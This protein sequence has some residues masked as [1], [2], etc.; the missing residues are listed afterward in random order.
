[1]MPTRKR[2]RIFSFCVA[3]I[4]VLSVSTVSLYISS[5]NYKRQLELSRQRALSE[6]SESID[7]IV[8]VLQKGQYTSSAQTMS[9]LS[10][11]LNAQALCAKTALSEIES[12]DIYT[13]DIY[14]FLS[15]VG[16]YTG[17]ISTKLSENSDSE[18]DTETISSLLSYAK[19]LS[20]SLDSVRQAYYDGSLTF[21][22]SKSNL[23]LYENEEATMFSD[24]FISVQEGLENYP[25]LV[26]D[27]PFSDHM[28]SLE[29]KAVKGLSQ[30]TRD[31][32]EK[33]AAEI[34][35]VSTAKLKR[36]SDEEGKLYLYCFSTDTKTV[37][38]TKLGGKL[39]YIVNSGYVGE[40]VI[41]QENAIERGAKFLR[42]IGYNSM[43]DSYYTTYDGVCTV[44]FAYEKSGAIC[45]PDLIKVGVSLETGEIVSFDARTYLMNHKD[46]NIDR[47]SD[48]K[49]VQAKEKLNVNLAV[50]SER[51]ALIPTESDKEYLCFEFR[52]KDKQGQEV[53][54]YI[55][56]E[57]FEERD[58]L[59]LLYSDGGVLTY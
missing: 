11:S 40:A 49:V 54:I 58:I 12:A 20:S 5:E 36:E 28:G 26:Y 16:D 55:D 52:C 10:S 22:K 53:L 57:T 59:I 50:L 48:E 7:A 29:S 35:G 1:M 23:N 18:I 37:G 8:L 15:Q 2:I 4:A 3:V 34:L 27:G 32:A 19:E 14:K 47:Q 41:D 33:Y 24:S 13:A 46:R 6:L 43:T 51:T 44:N 42:E 39:C 21:E 45:Y 9:K 31:E 56:C 25:T 38:I 30:I 17:S